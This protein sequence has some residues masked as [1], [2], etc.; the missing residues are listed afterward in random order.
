VIRLEHVNKAFGARKVL[1]DYNLTVQSGET[2]VVMGPSGAGKSVTLK[3]IVGL[4]YPDSGN[5]FVNDVDVCSANREQLRETRS[6]I[7]YLFQSGA[8]LNWMTVGQNV[9]LPLIENR[10]IKR[11]T[12][13]IQKLVYE[14]LK[15][16]NMAG[17]VH[18]YPS[19]ISG[20][21]RKRAA[22]A[23]VLVQEPKILLYDEPTAGL[24]PRMSA[25]IGNLI[26]DVRAKFGV[27][28]I[29]VTHDLRLAFE[30]ANRIGFM[31]LGR[32]LEIDEPLKLRAS[33][34]PIVRDFLEGRPFKSADEETGIG[35]A[36]QFDLPST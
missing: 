10:R 29:V 33:R 35:N 7:G 28:S 4:L 20:G 11:K 18:K 15:D 23:R 25:T 34:N 27:T 30:V 12:A 31:H 3:H 5:V 16:V 9:A 36:T 6:Q 13:E 22:L 24:D 8:L 32:L 26:N 19:E 1:I 21:M 2:F 17:E 14:R